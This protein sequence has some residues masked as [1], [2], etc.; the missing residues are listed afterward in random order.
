MFALSSSKL[1]SL[2]VH[3]HRLLRCNEVSKACGWEM[4]SRAWVIGVAC[5][6]QLSLTDGHTATSLPPLCRQTHCSEHVLSCLVSTIVLSSC[7]WVSRQWVIRFGSTREEEQILH[8]GGYVLCK[9]TG[10]TH[11]SLTEGKP[12]ANTSKKPLG[13]S[14]FSCG[15]LQ[16]NTLNTQASTHLP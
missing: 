6:W 12:F 5:K 14:G 8:H 16:W 1:F 4:P 3:L 7:F 9:I 13:R 10:L 2:S 11:S 15:N